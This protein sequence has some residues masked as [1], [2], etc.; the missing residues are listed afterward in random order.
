MFLQLVS[1]GDAVG[2]EVVL[3]LVELELDVDEGM[4]EI[5]ELVLKLE[6]VLGEREL[7]L[8]MDKEEVLDVGGFVVLAV[9]E[10][11]PVN[12]TAVVPGVDA[13]VCGGKGSVMN[14]VPGVDP[15]GGTVVVPGTD[16]LTYEVT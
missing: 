16:P 10:F 12:G 11:D 5:E 13:G 8:E 9:P 3:E 1:G 15:E 7:L 6:V 14:T 4:L 2:V